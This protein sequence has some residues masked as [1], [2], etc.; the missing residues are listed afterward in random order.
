M[1]LYCCLQCLKSNIVLHT[2]QRKSPITPVTPCSEITK[3]G[4]IPRS[5]IIVSKLS[6]KWTKERKHAVTIVV[7]YCW[8]T[9]FRGQYPHTDVTR[10]LVLAGELLGLKCPPSTGDLVFHQS[11]CIFFPGETN[12]LTV[13][14][15]S[16]VST[17]MY[18]A[19]PCRDKQP[20][21]P[22]LSFS[23]KSQKLSTCVVLDLPSTLSFSAVVTDTVPCSS[24]RYSSL[25]HSPT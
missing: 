23:P 22:C 2:P 1:N 19:L 5:F 21:A 25:T 11:L 6:D 24:L 13:L 15:P 12:G 9:L 4:V 20:L 8:N 7:K 10:C 16:A 3:D 18:S 14:S 17:K